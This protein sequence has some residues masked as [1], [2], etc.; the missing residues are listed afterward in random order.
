MHG[1]ALGQCIA[2]W[3]RYAVLNPT[4]VAAQARFHG[5][6]DLHYVEQLVSC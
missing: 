1:C 5:N 2:S 3:Y 6:T 4:L